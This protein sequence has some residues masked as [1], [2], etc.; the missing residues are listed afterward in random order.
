MRC[1][2]YLA[3]Y[4]RQTPQC[5]LPFSREENG[6]SFSRGADIV[7]MAHQPPPTKKS[8]F[9]LPQAA[10]RASSRA[11]HDC[12]PHGDRPLKNH[13][14]G[15]RRRRSRPSV[16]TDQAGNGIFRKHAMDCAEGLREEMLER[17]TGVEMATSSLG[18]RIS[19]VN[20][21]VRR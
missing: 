4:T 6:R 8:A 17:E 13:Q 12:E 21:G 19:I 14:R 3:A 7:A 15:T 11:S 9:L 10:Q 16:L 5:V 1:K 2:F 18:K 20:R